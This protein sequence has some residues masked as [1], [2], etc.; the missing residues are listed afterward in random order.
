MNEKKSHYY[1]NKVYKLSISVLAPFFFLVAP[2]YYIVCILEAGSLAIIFP[3]YGMV[4]LFYEFD[5]AS[6]ILLAIVLICTL[7]SQKFIHIYWPRFSNKITFVLF[8][9]YYLLMTGAAVAYLL[10]SVAASV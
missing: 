3:I 9:L 8:F 1:L 4:Y 5:I 6:L 7:I 10:V 2:Y